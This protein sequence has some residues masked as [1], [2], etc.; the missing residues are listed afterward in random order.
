MKSI[1]QLFARE[2]NVKAVEACRE[3][4]IVCISRPMWKQGGQTAET[5]NGPSSTF[6]RTG[7]EQR[8]PLL[9]FS[10]LS[11][12]V[13]QEIKISSTQKEYCN[14]MTMWFLPDSRQLSRQPDSLVFLGLHWIVLSAFDSHY[15]QKMYCWFSGSNS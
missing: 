11:L 12:S 15:L 5:V 3:D 2:L 8:Y 13:L 1:C 6:N 9:Y 4:R 7:W 10:F 14:V